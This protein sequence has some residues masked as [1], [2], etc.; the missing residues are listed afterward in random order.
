MCPNAIEAGLR[1]FDDNPE[2]AFVYGA[3]VEERGLAR[4]LMFMPAAGRSDLLRFN[5]VAM[6]ATAMF[7]RA[8]LLQQGGFDETLGMCEDWDAILRLS[9]SNSFAAH[10]N[11]VARYVLHEGNMSNNVA[12]MKSWME[13]VRAKE[14][15]RGLEK[16]E[17]KAWRD[18]GSALDA[19]YPEPTLR[20]SSRRAYRKVLRLIG[21]GQS[22]PSGTI[23]RP[24]ASHEQ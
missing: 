6:I 3:Y 14:R 11:I 24:L 7:E 21:L 16:D 20:G 15:D 1:C 4:R 5:C 9:R 2:A 10:P 23:N 19:I 12:E 8:P 13:V 18:G 22:V 17:L